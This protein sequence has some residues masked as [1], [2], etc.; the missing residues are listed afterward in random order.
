MSKP[1]VFTFT[2]DLRDKVEEAVVR[3]MCNAFENDSECAE[4]L[5]R[6]GYPGVEEMTAN[7]L[8]DE[9]MNWHGTYS[10]DEN[11]DDHLLRMMLAEMNSQI[12]EDTVLKVEGT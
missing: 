7:D 6:Y 10:L 3:R 4:S 8:M 1:V 9:Y 12:F 11:P 5:I 2:E